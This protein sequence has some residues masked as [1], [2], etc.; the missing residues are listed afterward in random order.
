MKKSAFTLIE[1]LV[2][3]VIIAILAGIALPVFG[4]VQEKAHATTCLNNLRQIGI[5]TAAFLSD[6]EDT[7]FA[8]TD[9]WP[10]ILNTDPTTNGPGKY[11]PNWK[12]FRSAFDKRP[13]DGAVS[14]GVNI[15]I[16]TRTADWDGSVAKMDAPSQLIYM[17]PALSAPLKN[18]PAAFTGT[19]AAPT[20][21]NPTAAASFQ[22]THMGYKQ[23]NA[24]YMDMHV[25]SLKFGPAANTDAFSNESGDSGN[26]RWRPKLPVT[27]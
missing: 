22:G 27:P 5:G 12:T 14:Y 19:S 25:A 3:I 16:L 9:K 10:Q 15:N 8:A 7:M 6:N 18:G 1:L 11:V 4:K 2:V 17:A 13:A 21:L 23:I 24:L 26:R 20:A